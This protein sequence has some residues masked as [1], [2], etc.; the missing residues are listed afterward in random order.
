MP[1]CVC[2]RVC[3]YMHLNPYIKY[4]SIIHLIKTF[5]LKIIFQ[6]VKF[7]YLY[8]IVLN[9]LVIENIPHFSL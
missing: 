8:L 5:K 4:V 7:Y 1:V 6:N 2:A 9:Y 3:I